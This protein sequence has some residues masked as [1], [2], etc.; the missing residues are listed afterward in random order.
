MKTDIM[1]SMDDLTRVVSKILGVDAPMTITEKSGQYHIMSEELPVTGM[2]A[3]LFDRFQVGSFGT[4]FTV[5]GAPGSYWFD[6]TAHYHHVT[7]GSNGC[8]LGQNGRNIRL[9]FDDGVWTQAYLK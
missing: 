8:A 4:L 5:G 7:G 2:M 6:L 1:N 9:M 3:L